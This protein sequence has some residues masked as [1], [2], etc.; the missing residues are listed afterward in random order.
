M[1]SKPETGDLFYAAE[2]VDPQG[3]PASI[4]D[5]FDLWQRLDRMV[6]QVDIPEAEFERLSEEQD[7]VTRQLLSLPSASAEDLARKILVET[8]NGVFDVFD[9]S[10]TSTLLQEEIF[11]LAGVCAVRRPSE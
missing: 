9:N 3:K 2:L 7:E 11:A 6:A 1:T 8:D 4:K 10:A 5:L